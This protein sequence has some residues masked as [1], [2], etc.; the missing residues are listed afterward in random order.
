MAKIINNG[1]VT[2]ARGK[3][4]KQFVYKKRG[5]DLLLVGMP[6]FDKNR[7]ITPEQEKV[8]D[9]FTAAVDFAKAMIVSTEYGKYYQAKATKTVSAYNIAFRDYQKA[10]VVRGID[11][12]EYSGAIGSTIEVNATDDFA[13]IKVKMS[14]RSSNGDLIEEGFATLKPID[15][16]LWIYMATKLN[17][18]VTGCII[19]ATAF[20]IPGNKGVLEVTIC[21]YLVLKQKVS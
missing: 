6:T 9:R 2:G 3:F 11:A 1:L 5:D 14:I 20:D 4:R 13:V 16:N 10:P 7:V 15:H 21:A 17:A 19:T 12:S 8:R 18:S